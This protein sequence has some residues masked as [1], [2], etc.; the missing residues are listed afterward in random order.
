VPVLGRS[1]QPTWPHVKQ[2]DE[3]S[4]AFIGLNPSTAD[5]VQND[6]TVR[7]CIG[8]AH[9]MGRGGLLML[10]MAAYRST[11][12]KGMLAVADPI[13]PDNTPQNLLRWA[14]KASPDRPAIAAWGTN[15]GRSERL[16]QQAEGIIHVFPRLDCLR[17]VGGGVHP[18]HPLYLLKKLRPVPFTCGGYHD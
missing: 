15:A 11:D 6:P 12:P 1:A 3:P 10:N 4:F 13:G 5:E 17:V 16:R 14:Q 7:R 8:Y 18:A 2:G 9:D